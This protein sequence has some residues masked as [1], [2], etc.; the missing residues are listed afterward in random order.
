MRNKDTLTDNS[1]VHG[2][3]QHG[4]SV[5]L[6][7]VHALVA[8]LHTVQPQVPLAGSG[9]LYVNTIVVDDPLLSEGE[10][11]G[12]LISPHHLHTRTDGWLV[13][14]WFQGMRD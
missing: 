9:V 6:A 2:V 14:G 4:V 12:P 1:E 13:D 7:G 11:G 10:D 8:V 3:G 5:D